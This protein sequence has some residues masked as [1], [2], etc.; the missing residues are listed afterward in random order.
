MCASERPS[1]KMLT[2]NALGSCEP[3]KQGC[4]LAKAALPICFANTFDSTFI[5]YAVVIIAAVF[6]FA[7]VSWVVSAHKWFTGPIKNI[8]RTTSTEDE[9]Q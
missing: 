5:D 4:Q 7:S 1:I 2:N 8:D 6:V 3:I 9:K